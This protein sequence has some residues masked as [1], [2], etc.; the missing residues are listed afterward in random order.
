MFRRLEQT[1]LALLTRADALC[2]RLYGWRFNPLYQSGT[3][4]VAL[5]LTLVATGTWLLLFYRVG[6]PWESVDRITADP[7]LGNWVRGLHR[8]ATDAAVVFTAIHAM[9]MFAQGRSWGA[10]SLAWISGVLLVVLML[11]AAWSG[12][13]M[14]W[15]VLGERL[16]REGARMA[17]AL[18]ILSEPVSRA[19]NGERPVPSVFFFITLFA[20]IGIPLGMGAMFWIHVKRLQRPAMLPPRPLLWG[21][22]G[23]LTAVALVRPVIMA[24]KANPFA[25]TAH[26]PFDLFVAFWVPLTDAWSGGAVLLMLIGT[27]A[28]LLIWPVLTTRRGAEAAALPPSF[29]DEDLCTGCTQCTIDCPYGAIEMVP[30]KDDRPTLVALVDPSLCVSCGICAGSCPPMGVGPAGRTGRD[31]LVGVQ[32][33]LKQTP[34]PA[35]GVVVIGCDHGAGRFAH[36]IEASGAAFQGVSCAGN[37]HTSAIERLLRGGADGVLIMACHPRDCWNREGPRWLSERIYHDREAELQPRVPRTRVR[38]THVSATEQPDAL[39]TLERFAADV[40]HL[41]DDRTVYARGNWSQDDTGL[42]EEAVEC[43]PPEPEEV[44]K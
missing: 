1:S 38:V 17:D 6:A 19:F 35:T 30:R 13:V 9:R 32:A 2:T 27:F 5:Y 28:A 15:D 16:A 12:Y 22:V 8:Y 39:A 3:I 31:Q 34:R 14:V 11:L 10:R 33:F 43:V 42:A 40:S 37:L 41:P 23:L 7:W 44:R 26:I 25:Q 24:P 29:V 36:A 20:H 21:V 4:V 18:P